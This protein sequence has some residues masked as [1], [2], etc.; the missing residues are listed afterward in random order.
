[1]KKIL[2]II[3]NT[4]FVLL[5]IIGIGIV[6]SLLP[7]KKNYKILSVMSGSMQPAISMGSVV[8]VKPIDRYK[9]GD[10]I[11]FTPRDAKTKKDY[12]THRITEVVRRND[13]YAYRTKGDASPSGDS[14]IVSHNRVLGKVILSIALIGYIIGYAKTLPG[15]V[16]IIVLATIIVYEEVKKIK[17][18]VGKMG[19]AKRTKTKKGTNKKQIVKNKKRKAKK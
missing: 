18:E 17:G 14:E 2:A 19:Q 5:I 3:V 9:V 4:V 15:L 7:F 10:I 8:V 11:T 6:F 16:I 12:T 1:M 13:L